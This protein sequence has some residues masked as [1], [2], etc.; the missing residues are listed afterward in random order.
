MKKYNLDIEGEAFQVEIDSV[1]N[2]TA[3]IS[4]NGK[5]FNV[6]IKE[7]VK[8]SAKTPVAKPVSAPVASVA[9]AAAPSTPSVNSDKSI[10]APLPGVILDVKVNVGDRVKEGQVVAVIEAMKME[11]DIESEMAGVIRSINVTK[12]ASVLEGAVIVTIE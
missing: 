2:N 10:K 11:N 6:I 1:H 12:G 9:P 3:S 5:H 8:Q 7:E 4:V